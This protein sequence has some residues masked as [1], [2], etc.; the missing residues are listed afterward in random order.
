MSPNQKISTILSTFTAARTAIIAIGGLATKIASIALISKPVSFATNVLTAHSVITGTF[1][2]NA[3]ACKTA[4]FVLIAK[5]QNTVLCPPGC[6][7]KN[8][9]LKINR[10][11]KNNILRR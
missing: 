1:Y 10:V 7:K 6:E 11:R 3:S 5:I 4:Y 9:F 8:I 2:G